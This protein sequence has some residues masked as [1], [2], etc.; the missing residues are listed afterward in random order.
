MKCS[1]RGISSNETLDCF[2]EDT[3]KLL[4]QSN[5]AFVVNRARRCAKV[6]SEIRRIDYDDRI[7]AAFDDYN[8]ALVY[9]TLK[10][11]RRFDIHNIAERNTKTPD[12]KIVFNDNEFFV[13]MK[14]L[15]F[16]DG[17]LGY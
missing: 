3:C 13:E 16:G 10:Y 9:Y 6:L 2:D 4:E 17:N 5:D 14:S 12:F 15:A 7:V 8:E 1:I 11:V